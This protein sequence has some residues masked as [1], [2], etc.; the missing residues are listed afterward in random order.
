ML[1]ELYCFV[2]PFILKW[3]VA[4]LVVSVLVNLFSKI[5]QQ[6]DHSHSSVV[7][8]VRALL[9]EWWQQVFQRAPSNQNMLLTLFKIS[10]RGKLFKSMPSFLRYGNM[11][12]LC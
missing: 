10:G 9:A 2:L 4:A 6:G 5:R 12:C 7:H 3:V 11:P 1:Q 8:Q